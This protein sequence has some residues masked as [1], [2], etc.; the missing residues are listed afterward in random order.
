MPVLYPYQPVPGSGVTVGPNAGAASI[1]LNAQSRQYCVT[2][3]LT[4]V[5]YARV[6]KAPI[7]PGTPAVGNV[8]TVADQAILGNTQVILTK[9]EGDDT[10][11]LFCAGAGSGHA[12]SGLGS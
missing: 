2:N 6:S 1:S 8:A 12:T 5:L 7:T 10:L 11:S 3:L 9:Q 4:T